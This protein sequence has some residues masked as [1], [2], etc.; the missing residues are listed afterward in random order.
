M[1]EMLARFGRTEH[2]IVAERVVEICP[3]VPNAADDRKL[4]VNPRNYPSA[5]ATR[6]AQAR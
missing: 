2:P 5:M 6:A 1:P 4:L 3:L